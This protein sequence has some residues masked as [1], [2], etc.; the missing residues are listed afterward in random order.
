MK[1]VRATK[2]ETQHTSIFRDAPRR[3]ASATSTTS[4]AQQPLTRTETRTTRSTT[5]TPART[6]LAK[7][8]VTVTSTQIIDHHCVAYT[9]HYCYLQPT[10]HTHYIDTPTASSTCCFQ[11][12]LTTSHSSRA[13]EKKTWCQCMSHTGTLSVFFRTGFHSFTNLKAGFADTL[14]QRQKDANAM[15][16]SPCHR[17]FAPNPWHLPDN[18]QSLP[19]VFRQ[20]KV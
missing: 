9:L 1:T 17:H 13:I 16:A 19:P 6:R 18:Q 10:P 8:S 11:R 12:R 3:T 14:I 20:S 2:Q 4:T 7:S 5:R 15:V